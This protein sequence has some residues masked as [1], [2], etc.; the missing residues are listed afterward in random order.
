MFALVS[1]ASAQLCEDADG[2]GQALLSTS[3][4]A[5]R[6]P[7]QEGARPESHNCGTHSEAKG[8]SFLECFVCGFLAQPALLEA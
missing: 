2:S 6:P 5:L 3:S 7:P 8:I 1:V 4:S